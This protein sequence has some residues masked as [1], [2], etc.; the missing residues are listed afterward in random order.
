[1]IDLTLGVL[2]SAD[3][4]SAFNKDQLDGL[5]MLFLKS[6]NTGYNLDGIFLVFGYFL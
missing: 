6:H 1:M 2:D 3:Y 5:M 4:L